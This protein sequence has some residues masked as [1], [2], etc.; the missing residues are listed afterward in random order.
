M[1]KREQTEP[2][3]DSAAPTTQW[4]PVEKQLPPENEDVLTLDRHGNIRNRRLP[5]LSGDVL[6]F[7]PD[8]LKPKKHITHW[9]PL[10]K[11]PKMN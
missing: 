11:A 2:F 4:I 3:A 7:R 5:K 10:P 6:L 9:M 8:G 1:E